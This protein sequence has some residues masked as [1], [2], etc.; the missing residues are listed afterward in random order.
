MIYGLLFF[1]AQAAIQYILS[2]LRR[3]ETKEEEKITLTSTDSNVIVVRA[4]SQPQC[5][6]QFYMVLLELDLPFHP[7]S[8]LCCVR[9]S[10]DTD[11]T[12]RGIYDDLAFRRKTNRRYDKVDKE[13]EEVS[14]TFL[15][16]VR[17]SSGSPFVS[18]SLSYRSKLFLL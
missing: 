9:A 12:R 2:L 13:E 18:D 16:L 15:S 1:Q 14:N 8:V 11:L 3:W 4:G 6:T 7:L 17:H 10:G 5:Y